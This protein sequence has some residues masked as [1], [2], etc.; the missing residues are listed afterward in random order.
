MAEP[1]ADIHRRCVACQTWFFI[2]A[3]EQRW[4]AQLAQVR[5]DVNVTLPWRC[6]ACRKER[7]RVRLQVQDDGAIEFLTC[8]DCGATFEFSGKDKEFW[9]RNEWAPP[10]RCRTCRQSRRVVA[11]EP[12]PSTE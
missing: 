1:G 8:V 6:L 7:R 12:S 3:S 2:T 5:P 9:A 10:L 4:F 11:E